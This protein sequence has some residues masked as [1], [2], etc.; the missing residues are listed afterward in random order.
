MEILYLP[1]SDA[2][3]NALRV[4]KT[5]QSDQQ[6]N[7]ILKEDIDSCWKLVGSFDFHK[8]AINAA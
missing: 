4:S 2:S 8:D 7:Y 1:T 6:S 5:N 3:R